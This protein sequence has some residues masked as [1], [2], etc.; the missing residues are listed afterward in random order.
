MA[1]I[2]RLTNLMRRR[3]L[4]VEIDEE[5]Q[6]HLEARISDNLAAG[7]TG[8][9]ARRDALRRFGSRAR[10][11]TGARRQHLRPGRASVARRAIRRAHPGAQPGAHRIAVISIAFGTGPTSRS[12]AWPIRSCCGRCPCGGQATCSPSVHECARHALPDL[13]VLPGLPGHSRSGA[14]LRGLAA[15]DY[16]QVGVTSRPGEAPRVRYGAFVSHNFFHVLG[17]DPI[18]GRG[19]LPEE[20]DG[21][22]TIR[23][24]S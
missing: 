18:I 20:D 15:Y 4:N 12:S 13:R 5:L 2:H 6:F 8:D 7:M 24:W 10:C 21:A 11:G 1:W 9:E 19:F 3:D 14:E 22:V 17:I 23:R 16:E